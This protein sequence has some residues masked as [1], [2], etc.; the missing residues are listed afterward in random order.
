V[1]NLIA[2]G[3]LGASTVPIASAE[4]VI[5]PGS[6]LST[7]EG[8]RAV[9][10]GKGSIV[11]YVATGRI[12]SGGGGVIRGVCGRLCVEGGPIRGGGRRGGMGGR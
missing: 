5:A 2:G 3:G 1:P 10:F 8:C 7:V 4:R 6:L 12:A 11:Q 9:L